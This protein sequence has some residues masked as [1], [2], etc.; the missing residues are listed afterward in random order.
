[1]QLTEVRCGGS[2]VVSPAGRRATLDTFGGSFFTAMDTG[3]DQ[4][5]FGLLLS[6]I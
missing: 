4:A 1:L 3:A 5:R 6:A 2:S